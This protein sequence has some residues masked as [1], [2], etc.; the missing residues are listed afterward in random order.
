MAKGFESKSVAAQQELADDP[1]P[2][3]PEDDVDPQLRSRR[4][5]LELARADVERRLDAAQ[6]KPLQKMLQQA[7]DALN[8]E[9]AALD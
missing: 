1:R 4:R 8:Q 9:I 2:R 5:G 7:L 6:A 3:S